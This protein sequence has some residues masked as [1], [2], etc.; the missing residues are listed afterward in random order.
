MISTRA[1]TGLQKM[2]LKVKMK[3]VHFDSRADLKP[4]SSE[5]LRGTAVANSFECFSDG[6]PKSSELQ[7]SHVLMY[8]LYVLIP[9]LSP[10]GVFKITFW[11]QAEFFMY[12]V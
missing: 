4:N 3:G 5:L 9:F 6:F 8:F 12:S 11:L 10:G 2:R 1:V 7:Y